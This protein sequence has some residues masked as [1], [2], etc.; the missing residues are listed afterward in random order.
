MDEEKKNEPRVKERYGPGGLHRSTYQLKPRYSNYNAVALTDKAQVRKFIDAEVAGHGRAL[1]LDE[2]NSL[3]KV[4]ETL[5]LR[6]VAENII[7]TAAG[8]LVKDLVDEDHTYLRPAYNSDLSG[9]WELS[10]DFENPEAD[11]RKKDDWRFAPIWRKGDRFILRRNETGIEEIAEMMREAGKDVDMEAL[12]MNAGYLIT[13][14][15]SKFR[16]TREMRLDR[17]PEEFARALRPVRIMDHQDALDLVNPE[18]W[19]IK[20]VMLHLAE[21]KGVPPWKLAT[22]LEQSYHGEGPFERKEDDEQKS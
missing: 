11:R 13:N 19:I 10:K 6:G 7:T 2:G 8:F 14:A 21:Y 20:E 4:A 15:R 16:T 17:L 18:G 12:R 3:R 9:L 5:G 22:L 1:E